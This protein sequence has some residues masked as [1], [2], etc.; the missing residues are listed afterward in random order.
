MWS[1]KKLLKS[2]PYH[3]VIVFA[4]I[5]CLIS[6]IG[7]SMI[8][9]SFGDV[10]VENVSVVTDLGIIRGYLLVPDGV[11]ENPAPGSVVSHG[12]SS[13]AESVESWYIEL[14]RRGY[15]VFA[16][17]MYGHGDSTIADEAYAD[18]I[19]YESNGLYDAVEY[20]HTLNIVDSEKVAVMGHSLGGGSS[21]KVAAYYTALEEEALANG[22]TPEEAHALN[23]LAACMPIG[24]P[25]E[26]I[27]DGLPE[28]SSPEFNGFNCHL[29]SV[30]GKA[31]DF[32]SWLQKDILTNDSG[33]RWLKTQ[34][35]IEAEAVEEGHFY[36]N[37]ENGYVFALWNPNEIHNQNFIS[38]KTASY[39]VDFFEEVFGAPNPIES[40]NQIWGWKQLFSFIGII[41]FFLFVLPC[42]FFVLKTPAFQTLEREN[43]FVLPPLVGDAK[44]KYLKS[45]FT[46]VL[47]NTITFLPVVMI[48][49]LV[50]INPVL[51]QASTS[52][53]V[54]WGLA[55]G[56]STLIAVRRGTGLKYK[57][58]AKYY[59][60]KTT[61]KEFLHVLALSL[62][63]TV[64]TYSLLFAVKYLFNTD[65]RIWTYAIRPFGFN[66]I[67]VALRYLPLFFVLQF[68][69]GIAIRR[70]NFDNWSDNK[71]IAFS[72][73]MALIPIAILLLITY[74][75]ILF[76]GSPTFGTS[77]SNLILLAMGQGSIKLYSYIISVGITAFIHV[78]SQKYT[79]NIWAGVLIN[80][81]II[82]MITVANCNSIT[83][84]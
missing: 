59:G 60:F 30:L 41:G 34:T 45:I 22:A 15:V 6:G 36:T 73:T 52:G 10:T 75:P 55:C 5:L 21:I 62:T 76:T 40:S 83:A 16:P 47:I 44:K 65:F 14:A 17:N 57:Q 3:V 69:N 84:F 38:G 54:A 51:P 43:T 71:R 61:W 11:S 20:L 78:K 27:I 9:T 80:T 35:G 74:V 58:N 63:V 64:M 42:L 19:S 18:T 79:G 8:L 26:A 50:I 67:T 24:Y 48:G 81:L 32:Q 77:G 25:L 72:T 66:R 39:V 82:C 2:K 68:A 56:A 53:F 49:M 7:S 1:M 28:L 13:S 46:G 29:G 37:T 12:A 31:D 33:V 23:K 4:L 70:N